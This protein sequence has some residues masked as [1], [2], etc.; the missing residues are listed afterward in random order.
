MTPHRYTRKGNTTHFHYTY[1][2]LKE[3]LQYGK[4]H[5]N[6]GWILTMREG[7]LR[8]FRGFGTINNPC[9][10]LRS[11]GIV[12]FEL[13]DGVMPEDYDD[14]ALIPPPLPGEPGSCWQKPTLFFPMGQNAETS[15]PKHIGNM[16]GKRSF[17]FD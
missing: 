5:G 14:K 7:G 13:F 16:W 12:W 17:M 1:S 15:P 2:E 4:E 10:V 3:F 8:T 6:N 9:R 11:Y